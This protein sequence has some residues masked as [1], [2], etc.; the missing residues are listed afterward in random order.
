MSS[1]FSI[2][3]LRRLIQRDFEAGILV[4]APSKSLD[5]SLIQRNNK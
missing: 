2:K 3:H 5:T 4:G 1:K